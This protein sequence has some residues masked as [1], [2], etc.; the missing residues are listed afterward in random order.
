MKRLLSLML[1]FV[2]LVSVAQITYPYNPDGNADS[3]IGVAD[4]QDLL[5]NYGLPFSPAE[6][7]FQNQPLSEVLTNIL[8]RLDSL[9]NIQ[10]D[11]ETSLTDLYY[12]EP[13]SCAFPGQLN[14]DLIAGFQVCK[15]TNTGSCTNHIPTNCTGEFG[16][17]S[18]PMYMSFEV[19]DTVW[20]EINSTF[21]GNACSYNNSGLPVNN[22]LSSLPFSDEWNPQS[23]G[24]GLLQQHGVAIPGRI[25]VAM[26]D[27]NEATH[28]TEIIDIEDQGPFENI[29]FWNTNGE[30]VNQFYAA[31]GGCGISNGYYT[32]VGSILSYQNVALSWFGL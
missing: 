3:L 10:S 18:S 32:T 27:P 1:F 6:I 14:Y 26:V 5:T 19:S 31:Y 24:W 2:S 7:Q 8:W 22:A 23:D 21:K 13:E 17:S 11:E 4:M 25:F 12:S 28:L 30:E 16:T 9:S 15:F 29:R 20:I